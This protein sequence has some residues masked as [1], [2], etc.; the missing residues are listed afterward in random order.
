MPKFTG[1]LQEYIWAEVES[2]RIAYQE[3]LCNFRRVVEAILK[4][5][6]EDRETVVFHAGA[7]RRRAHRRYMAAIS[8]YAQCLREERREVSSLRP[9]Y[10]DSNDGNGWPGEKRIQLLPSRN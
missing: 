10:S 3:A 6:C 9:F 4:D 8:V 5:C 7:V 2:A 1:K